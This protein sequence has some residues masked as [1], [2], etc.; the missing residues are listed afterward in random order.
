MF[1]LG[2]NRVY[3]RNKTRHSNTWQNQTITQISS[4]QTSWQFVSVGQTI[5]GK[6]AGIGKQAEKVGRRGRQKWRPTIW[7]LSLS[8]AGYPTMAAKWMMPDLPSMTCSRWSMMSPFTMCMRGCSATSLCV[9]CDKWA[10]TGN[11]WGI[12]IG[13]CQLKR[14]KAIHFE[15]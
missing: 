1:S 3:I 11:G 2:P 10:T 4:W 5:F 12:K 8:Q 7:A 15:N 9:W 14:F 6:E 13:K